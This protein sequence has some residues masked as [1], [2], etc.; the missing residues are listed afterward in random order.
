MIFVQLFKTYFTQFSQNTV[1]DFAPI[2]VQPAQE[3]VRTYSEILSSL[4]ISQRL[5]C[6]FH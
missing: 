6:Y 2:Y 4:W 3:Y 5:K 1:T